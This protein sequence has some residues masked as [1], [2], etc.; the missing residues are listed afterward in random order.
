[1]FSRLQELSKKL[2]GNGTPEENQKREQTLKLILA[3]AIT[4][5]A[6][7]LGSRV[8]EWF[9]DR[10]MNYESENRVDEYVGLGKRTGLTG[11]LTLDVTPREITVKSGDP[12]KV[13][14]TFKNNSPNDIL[15]SKELAPVPSYWDSSQFPLKLK[16]TRNGKEITHS[17]NIVLLAEQDRNDFFTI[18]GKQNKTVEVDLSQGPKGGKWNNTRPG[19]YR[20]EI[21]YETYR[22]GRAIGIK[23]WTGMTNHAVINV[24]VLRTGGS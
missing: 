2:L 13:D 11:Q 16:I 4:V 20:Y 9:S 8:G 24:E 5:T 3:L 21:W 17:G 1:M 15:L 19:T 6:L 23:A 14:V 12:I 10:R 18:S 7:L 22:S